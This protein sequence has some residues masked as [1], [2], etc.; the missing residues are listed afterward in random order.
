MS[1]CL[2]CHCQA[3]RHHIKSRGSGGSDDNC[4]ILL[5]CRAH[6]VE[7]HKIGRTHFI[8]KYNLISLMIS[9]GW[10]FIPFLNKWLYDG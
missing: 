9:K 2:L 7:I 3:E 6:H 5:L 10:Q 8:E 4:N 1:N